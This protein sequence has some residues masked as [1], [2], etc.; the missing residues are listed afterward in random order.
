MSWERDFTKKYPCPCGKG[1]YEVSSYS[2]DWM[3][4]RYEYSMLCPECKEKYTYSHAIINAHPGREVERG[5]VL[6]SDLIYEENKRNEILKKANEQCW[7]IWV[8]KFSATTSK[9]SMWK[10]LSLDGKY[11][12]ALG[13][14]YSHTKGYNN[15]QIIDHINRYFSFHMIYQIYEIC[16][17]R[18][19]YDFL[20]TNEDEL[21]KLVKLY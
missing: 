10:L 15:E 20:G 14:F 21:Y 13:T 2:D 8:S 1:E 4:S 12:P 9:K 7:D 16:G 5:W 19:D 6:K 3:R 17:I 11:S 18:L